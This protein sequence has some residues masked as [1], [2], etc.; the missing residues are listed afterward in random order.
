MDNMDR[1]PRD[2]ANMGGH[3]DIVKLFDEFADR[4][5][6]VT[7]Q[8]SLVHPPHLQNQQV[9][10]SKKKVKLLAPREPAVLVKVGKEDC[11]LRCLLP[12][13]AP[14]NTSSISLPVASLSCSGARPKKVNSA[15]NA[16]AAQKFS[17]RVTNGAIKQT[18]FQ[19]GECEAL[20]SSKA[21]VSSE[22]DSHKFVK[23]L[24]KSGKDCHAA[25]AHSTAV[26]AGPGVGMRKSSNAPSNV[27]QF[28]NES[29]PSYDVNQNQ[30]NHSYEA[31]RARENRPSCAHQRVG[32]GELVQRTAGTVA[33]LDRR[34]SNALSPVHNQAMINSLQEKSKLG[35]NVNGVGAINGS[36]GSSVPLTQ[37]NGH[38]TSMFTGSN[39]PQ[40]GVYLGGD[41]RINNS[42]GD[43][44]LNNKQNGS[45]SNGP[46]IS[47]S[48]NGQSNNCALGL[49]SGLNY[50][51][52]RDR[53]VYFVSAFPS[54]N[55][56]VCPPAASH[57]QVSYL[58]QY[59]TPPSQHGFSSGCDDT[60]PKTFVPS[61]YLS[62]VQYPTPSPD[63]WS[64]SSPHSD[65]STSSP[66]NVQHPQ[67]SSGCY[68]DDIKTEPCFA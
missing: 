37:I 67:L 58:C 27:P 52:E 29:S 33:G 43:H 30:M 38:D 11:A 40:R 66:F 18:A 12:A 34:R 21:I 24:K 1:L 59:L 36:S 25:G 50:P 15:P 44:V 20:L 2:V 48:V 55:T 51:A 42:N 57:P 68:D 41:I 23:P 31:E 64:T 6:D 5:S 63:S 35:R 19:K 22:I 28:W 8:Q 53:S 65:C 3:D 9:A 26:V 39:V 46:S 16:M 45:R 61:C 62:P 7:I 10:A 13:I 4:K 54:R 14:N 56:S 17:P 60:P 49:Y 47:G 32:E